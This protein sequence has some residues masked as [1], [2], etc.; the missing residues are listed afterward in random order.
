[1]GNPNNTNMQILRAAAAILVLA[2][3]TVQSLPNDAVVPES[4]LLEAKASHASAAAK[5]QELL[6]AGKTEDECKAL[7]DSTIQEISDNVD[8]SQDILNAVDKGEDCEDL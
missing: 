3:F 6:Q 5:I 8:A 4:S 2:A 7:A 1:M